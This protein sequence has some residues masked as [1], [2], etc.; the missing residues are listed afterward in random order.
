MMKASMKGY[1]DFLR[2]LK[3]KKR[4][5]KADGG[6]IGL[7]KGGMSEE[8][9]ALFAALMER[10]SRNAYNKKTIAMMMDEQFPEEFDSSEF[11]DNITCRYQ[12]IRKS[13]WTTIGRK[14]ARTYENNTRI[15]ERWRRRRSYGI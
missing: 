13:I 7:E 3:K 1:G 9:T 14:E 6:R 11:S 10:H 15:C 2:K 4:K 8:R 12:W 5:A